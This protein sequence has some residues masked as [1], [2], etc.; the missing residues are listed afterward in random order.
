[1]YLCMNIF[2]IYFFYIPCNSGELSRKV[3]GELLVAVP[4]HREDAQGY[5]KLHGRRLQ[6]PGLRRGEV[7]CPS[8]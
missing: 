7:P 2:F 3:D 4:G 5:P 6:G 8:R 1:M